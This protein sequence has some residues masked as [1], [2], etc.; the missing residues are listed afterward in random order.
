MRSDLVFVAM[1]RIPNRYQLCQLAS[2]ATRRMHQPNTRVT[3]TT[4]HVLSNFQAFNFRPECAV[5]ARKVRSK[6]RRPAA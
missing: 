5:Q 3:D 4:N 1:D 2:K 6:Q